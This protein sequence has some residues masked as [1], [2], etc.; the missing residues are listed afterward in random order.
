MAV[1]LTFLGGT[2][3]HKGAA[4]SSPCGSGHLQEPAG[5][6]SSQAAAPGT[7]QC[8][9]AQAASSDDGGLPGPLPMFLSPLL[10]S[11]TRP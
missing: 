3:A 4:G 2:G 9:L 11:V 10:V 6:V 1:C 8:P 7:Q 5:G